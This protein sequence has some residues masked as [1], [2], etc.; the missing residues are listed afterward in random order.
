MIRPAPG[1]ESSGSLRRHRQEHFATGH[2][3]FVFGHC[4][5]R[6]LQRVSGTHLCFKGALHQLLR[7]LPEAQALPEALLPHPGG[8]P[9]TIDGL[10]F[11]NE[12][13][14]MNR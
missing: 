7:F 13:L 2:L 12:G 1:A 8:Q 14:V 9:K 4:F 11:E 6:I 3:G 10:I 5:W